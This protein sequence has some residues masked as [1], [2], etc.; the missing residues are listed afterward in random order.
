MEE[1]KQYRGRYTGPEIDNILGIVAN[2][3]NNW[4]ASYSWG[5]HSHAGYAKV[6]R[7]ARAPQD[8]SIDRLPATEVQEV[9]F[10]VATRKIIGVVV[11]RST[12]G[13]VVAE[14][15]HSKFYNSPNGMSDSDFQTKGVCV[16]VDT[17]IYR[18][19][20]TSFEL[21]FSVKDIDERLSIL[22]KRPSYSDLENTV[23]EICDGKYAR[24]DGENTFATEVYSKLG[25]FAVNSPTDWETNGAYMYTEDGEGHMATDY[26]KVRDNIA[27]GSITVCS[28]NEEYDLH[29]ALISLGNYVRQNAVSADEKDVWNNHVGTKGQNTIHHTHSNKS[30]IDGITKGDIDRWNAGGGEVVVKDD[31]Y[32]LQR[33]NIVVGK[34]LKIGSKSDTWYFCN[35]GNKIYLNETSFSAINYG[36]AKIYINGEDMTDSLYHPSIHDVL[37]IDGEEIYPGKIFVFRLKEVENA[38]D[39]V[40]IYHIE[41]KRISDAVKYPTRCPGVYIHRGVVINERSENLILVGTDGTLTLQYASVVKQLK[42]EKRGERKMWKFVSRKKVNCQWLKVMSVTPVAKRRWKSQFTK[43]VTKFWCNAERP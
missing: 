36:Y 19:D 3:Y 33:G 9:V 28:P 25:F 31:V 37:A 38:E 6:Y 23:V 13:G 26:L 40:N 16:I 10:D 22:E 35:Q 24:L 1:I 32:D 15:Y 20:G 41:A 18:Y 4:N 34:A 8:Y 7:V 29:D 30:V 43:I 27:A 5:D 14:S 42:R 11:R 17:D 2:G 12:D 39:N 21:V